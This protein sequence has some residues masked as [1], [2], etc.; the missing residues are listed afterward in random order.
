ML[1]CTAALLLF[2][3]VSAHHLYRTSTVAFCVFGVSPSHFP[4]G[5]AMVHSRQRAWIPDCPVESRS[6]GSKAPS[7]SNSQHHHHPSFQTARWLPRWES[8]L[9]RKKEPPTHPGTP[10]FFFFTFSGRDYGAQAQPHTSIRLH[11]GS[12]HRRTIRNSPS[13]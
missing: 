5:T 7:S 12:S 8:K 9:E 11:P 13:I 1:Q 6:P 3:A 4:A 2:L 10:L